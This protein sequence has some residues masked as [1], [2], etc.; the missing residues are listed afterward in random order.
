MRMVSDLA[1][2]RQATSLKGAAFQ[3]VLIAVRSVEMS[4]HPGAEI[5][6][7]LAAAFT[8][9]TDRSVASILTALSGMGGGLSDDLLAYYGMRD[10]DQPS[11][12]VH[13]MLHPQGVEPGLLFSR[14]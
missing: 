7:D 1:P 4:G 11:R 3:A 8:G 14:A 13:L 10:A 2:Y 6:A 9:H 12:M 5:E